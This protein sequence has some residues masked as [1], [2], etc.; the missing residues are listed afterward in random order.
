ME[1]NFGTI[2]FVP[3]NFYDAPLAYQIAEVKISLLDISFWVK[4]NSNVSFCV[5][6]TIICHYNLPVI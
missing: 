6:Y 5:S 2:F 1:I 4:T 3:V